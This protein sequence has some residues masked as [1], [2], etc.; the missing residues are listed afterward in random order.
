MQE[1]CFYE[2]LVPSARL[3]HHSECHILNLEKFIGEETN[4]ILFSNLSLRTSELQLVWD[5]TNGCRYLWIQWEHNCSSLSALESTGCIL[6][7]FS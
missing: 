2:T 5:S 3:C 7:I 4:S 1:T 6:P